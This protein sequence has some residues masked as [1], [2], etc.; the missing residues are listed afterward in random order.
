MIARPHHVALV[1]RHLA[2]TDPYERLCAAE[3]LG[4]IGS[5]EAMDALKTRTGDSNIRVRMQVA[6]R[7]AI[8]PRGA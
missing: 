6:A 8:G 3:A 2:V 4:R 7:L 5:A 1:S